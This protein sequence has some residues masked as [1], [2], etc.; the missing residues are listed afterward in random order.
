M[1]RT[2]ET[3]PARALAGLADLEALTP[4]LFT[5]ALPMAAEHE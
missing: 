5:W 3:V 4:V 2:P 1:I